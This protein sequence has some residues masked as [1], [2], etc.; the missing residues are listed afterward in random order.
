MN[1]FSYA[2]E[3]PKHELFVRAWVPLK[4]GEPDLVQTQV[5]LTGNH[6]KTIGGH[7]LSDPETMEFQG[8]KHFS[9]HA[10]NG[11]RY[12]VEHEKFNVETTGKGEEK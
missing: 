2:L 12:I 4:E 3:N 11:T 10:K 9:F 5:I 6:L 8:T 1:C 7:M